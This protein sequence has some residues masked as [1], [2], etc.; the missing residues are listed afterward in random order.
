MTVR[1]IQEL[2]KIMETESKKLKEMFNNELEDLK[3]KQINNTITEM[4]NTLERINRIRWKN[5]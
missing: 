5:E 4:G 3:N 1:M 2:G